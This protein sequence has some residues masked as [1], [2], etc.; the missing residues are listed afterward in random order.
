MKY[1]SFKEELKELKEDAT[2]NVKTKEIPNE[3]GISAGIYMRDDPFNTNS[4]IVNTIQL[5]EH[6]ELCLLMSFHIAS[7]CFI[8]FI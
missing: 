8:A 3:L 5:Q 1:L 4:G 7:F 6:T 2:S